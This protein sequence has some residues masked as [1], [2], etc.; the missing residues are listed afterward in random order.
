MTIPLLSYP[1][2]RPYSNIQPFT[3]RDGATYLLQ[4]ETLLAWIRNDLVPHIDKEVSELA[5]NWAE[6]SAELISTWEQMSAALITRVEQAEASIGNAVSEAE[7]AKA[8]AEA[9]R[10][11]A[12]LY[13]SQAEEIQDVAVTGIF[14]DE[15]SALR[16]A[17]AGAFAPL[18]EFASLSDMVESGRLSEATIDSR[19]EDVD[20]NA[21]KPLAKSVTGQVSPLTYV[22]VLDFGVAVNASTDQSSA[23]QA[24]IDAAG[25][26]GVVRFPPGV[27]RL[28]T[29]ITVPLWCTI[30]G[31]N[32]GHGAGGTAPTELRFTMTE[33][34]AVTAA[35]YSKFANIKLRGSGSETGN[36][37]VGIAGPSIT[38]DNVSVANFGTGI[39]L[40]DAYYS[41][42]NRCEFQRNAIGLQLI[43]CY[44][45]SMF[46]PNMYCGSTATDTP[47]TGI[48]GAARSLNI[49]GGSIEGYAT[50]VS[51]Q[52]SQNLNLFGVYFETKVDANAYGILA[53]GRTN[54]KILAIGCMV[55]LNGQAAWIRFTNSTKSALE[56][57]SNN[58]AGSTSNVQPFAYLIDNTVAANIQND[59][60][61]DVSIA[62]AVYVTNPLTLR[63]SFVAYPQALNGVSTVQNVAWDS[64]RIVKVRNAITHS[65]NGAVTLSVELDNKITLSANATSSAFGP[66]AQS[67]SEIAVTFVQ[68]ATGGRTYVWPANARFAGNVAPNDTTPSTMTT[69]RFKYDGSAG[70]WH[71]VGRAVAVPVA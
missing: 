48:S 59:A 29:G 44:N 20:N 62:N 26:G 13:A 4:V 63:R 2:F 56:A 35:N 24:A 70:R 40:T 53:D 46:A 54:V 22:N 33:G 69:V 68:D 64:R 14:N 38:F 45:V 10:D 7:A 66:D 6:T 18:G 50:G 41:V 65:A 67:D 47:K 36:S 17:I 15:S 12:E 31:N 51:V 5:A 34:V 16:V 30:E 28:E 57:N 39:K 52:N 8:A 11:L 19:F 58:F 42:F 61:G 23:I 60:W 37:L 21:V 32:S 43:G 49:Y 3:V 27:Y 9:A 71:E 1:A 25:Q 55:Y